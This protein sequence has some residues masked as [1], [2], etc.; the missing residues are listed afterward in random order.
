MLRPLILVVALTLPGAGA[1]QCPATRADAAAGL[2]VITDDGSTVVIRRGP[3]GLVTEDWTYDGGYR[4][5]VLAL[6]GVHAVQ[7]G[8]IG[9]DDQLI[10][11]TVDTM[12]YDAPL[13]GEPPG[14]RDW[15]TPGGEQR[16]AGPVVP[17]SYTSSVTGLGELAIGGCGYKSVSISNR[18][19]GGERPRTE[20]VDF[21]PALG[22]AV[23]RGFT[24]EDGDLTVITPTAISL[25]EN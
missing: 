9:P 25:G 5:R 17:V 13:P 23:L 24:G 20:V 18:I 11:E 2:T 16:A 3:D 4:Q 6:H 12:T 10:A 21:L 1:A 15:S 22:I 14:V 8:E 7:I 19:E